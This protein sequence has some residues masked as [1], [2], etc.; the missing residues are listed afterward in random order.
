LSL[1][2]LSGALAVVILRLAEIGQFDF[3]PFF[4][5]KAKPSANVSSATVLGATPDFSEVEGVAIRLMLLA[6]GV[7]PLFHG[8]INIESQCRDVF[9]QSG[10]WLRFCFKTV[11]WSSMNPQLPGLEDLIFA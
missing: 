2:A 4:E 8:T 10:K 6:H 11:S 1:S 5:E 9:L 3:W 7:I